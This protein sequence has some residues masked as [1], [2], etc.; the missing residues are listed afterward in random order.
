MSELRDQ[1]QELATGWDR[2]GEEEYAASVVATKRGAKMFAARMEAWG[3][4]RA[5]SSQA[6]R[7]I[8]NNTPDQSRYLE[9][10]KELEAFL[11]ASRGYLGSSGDDTNEQVM[12][13]VLDVLHAVSANA[14][15]HRCALLVAARGDGWGPRPTA[16]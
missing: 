1:L 10:S 4:A 14:A 16:G 5:L 8:L 6:L 7:R 13:D 11:E 12:L 9:M 2:M 15:E 3:N